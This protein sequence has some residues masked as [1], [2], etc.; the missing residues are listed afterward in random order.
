MKKIIIT[1][2]IVILVGVVLF[3]L[4]KPS[5]NPDT[6]ESENT[7]QEEVTNNPPV[8]T[9]T[10]QDL[11]PPQ[12]VLG[13]SVEGRDIMAYHFGTGDDELLFIGGIHAGYSWNTVLLAQELV[14]YLETNEASLP[15]NIKVTVIPVMNPDGLNK[16]VGT[17][18]PNFSPSSVPSSQATQ[19]SGRF[20]ANNVD[21]NRNFDCDWK[22]ESTWQS[23]KVSGG[24][25]AFS[26]PESQAIK[27]YVE[28]KNLKAIVVWYSAAGGVYASSCHNE[29][30]KMTTD[31]T[32]LYAKASGYS[33]YSK[34]NFYEI[35][36]DMVNWF[37]KKNIPAISVLLTNHKDVEWT[38]NKAGIEKMIEFYGNKTSTS[39]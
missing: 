10:V 33:G 26:E 36:G 3:L 14:E 20:N 21:L 11:N 15:A 9:T 30:M 4:F 6:N 7:N 31:L 8:A 35:T 22:P 37:A 12:T 18:S 23:R 13:K 17:S 27:N 1:V 38:K 16:V 19:I 28:S 34:F 24:S 25:A 32:S 2:V 39:N 29:D 5:A